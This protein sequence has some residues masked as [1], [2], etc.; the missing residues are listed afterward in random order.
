MFKD[1][2]SK[3]DFPTSEHEILAFWKANQVYEQSL[4]KSRGGKPFVF[5]EDRKSVV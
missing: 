3:F 5:F 1:V 4:E 2:P